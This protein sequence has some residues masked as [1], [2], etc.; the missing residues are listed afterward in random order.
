M[1]SSL[2]RNTLFISLLGHLTVLSIFTFSLGYKVPENEFGHIYSWGSILRNCDLIPV[3]PVVVGINKKAG[4]RPSL[5]VLPKGE[6][7]NQDPL[8]SE[9]YFKPQVNLPANQEKLSYVEELPPASSVRKRKEQVIMFHPHL[10]VNFLLFFKDRQA[11]HIELSFNIVTN[12]GAAYS[13]IKRKISSGNLEADLLSM[14]YISHYL[15]LQQTRFVPNS[16][17][18]VKIDLSTQND[19]F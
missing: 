10:P 18:S 4:F 14:R 1:K 6:N 12:E 8:V 7:N 5:K 19:Q 15:F 11:V 17:Q 16:W 9:H 3:L 2:F 13:V